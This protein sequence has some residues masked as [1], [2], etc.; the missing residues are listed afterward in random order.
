MVG[1]K[2]GDGNFHVVTLTNKVVTE[3]IKNYHFN[4]TKIILI[5]K[6][7]EVTY[8]LRYYVYTFIYKLYMYLHTRIY[9]IHKYY[10]VKD[11]QVLY[12]ITELS[13]R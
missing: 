10:E 4:Y 12:Y 1:E 9:L 5:Y 13:V 2:E 3:K 8:D 6:F 11:N 7:T